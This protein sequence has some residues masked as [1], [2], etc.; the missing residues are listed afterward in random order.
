[1]EGFRLDKWLW[2]AR[3][4]K[5]RAL[6]QEAIEKGRVKVSGHDVKPSRE[7]R[8][9]DVIVVVQ[10]GPGGQVQKEI[11]VLALSAMRGP[12]SVAQTLYSESA[13]SVVKREQAA[14]AAKLSPQPGAD[15]KGRPTKR[16]RREIDSVKL[17]FAGGKFDW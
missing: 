13:E 1:M 8:V 15:I 2:A 3:F 6:S 10:P 4:Y 7:V 5:T 11:T 14:L 9:G 12:A 17:K 16:E